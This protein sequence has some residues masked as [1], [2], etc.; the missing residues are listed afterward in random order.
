ML[1]SIPTIIEG[2]IA[3]ELLLCV[4]RRVFVGMERIFG[5]AEAMGAP[6][7][8]HLSHCAPEK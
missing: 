4:I 7:G 1:L 6:P 8:T 2:F 5:V 3:L